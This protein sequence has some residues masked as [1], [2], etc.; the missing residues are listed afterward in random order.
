MGYINYTFFYSYQTYNEN[1]RHVIFTLLYLQWFIL[2]N[3]HLA[4]L[5]HVKVIQLIW[6]G[7]HEYEITSNL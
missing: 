4:T 6:T 5:L 3:H 7:A 2:I 1:E